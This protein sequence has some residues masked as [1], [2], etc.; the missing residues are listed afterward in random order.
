M[1]NNSNKNVKIH[2]IRL[3]IAVFA[4]IT[5]LVVILSD[6]ISTNNN[7]API[8]IYDVSATPKPSKEPVTYEPEVSNMPESTVPLVSGEPISTPGASMPVQ[9]TSSPVTREPA[10]KTPQ[11]SPTPMTKEPEKTK[12]PVIEQ[13]ETMPPVTKAPQ[14]ETD[15]SDS[16]KE[17]TEQAVNGA[18]SIKA[19]LRCTF[20]N[21]S[22]YF[23]TEK[24][25][26][27]VVFYKESGRDYWKLADTPVYS[28]GDGVYKGSIC[29]L[30]EGKKYDVKIE[31]F[32]NHKLIARK[33][34]N[35]TT[36]T[37]DIKIEKTIKLSDFIKEDSIEGLYLKNIK[38]TSK[39]YIRIIGD[40]NIAS[41]GKGERYIFENGVKK[42][43]L[44]TQE[45][46]NLNYALLLYGCE[47]VVL[48]GF[49]V[50]GGREAGVTIYGE[51]HNIILREF[52]ISQFGP[53]AAY[54]DELGIPYDK[55]DEVI[56][57]V[58][59]LKL[60][61]CQDV[62]FENSKIHSPKVHA[63]TWNEEYDSDTHPQGNSAIH[64][65]QVR[66][67]IVIRNNVLTGSKKAYFMDIIEGW[68]NEY[69]NGGICND[70]DIYGNVFKYANDDA[71][72]LDG[73]QENIRVYD[74]EF[75]NCLCGVSVSPNY[76][77]PSYIFRNTF[78]AMEDSSEKTSQCIK[79]VWNHQIEDGG[80]TFVYHNTFCTK[81]SVFALYREYSY[82]SRLVTAN[83][84]LYVHGTDFCINNYVNSKLHSYDY[85]L[86]Y[87]SNS[88][89]FA[90]NTQGMYEHNG[91]FANPEFVD[92]K[93]GNF[94][95]KSTSPGIDSG[96]VINNFSD[97]YLGKAPDMGR[98][99]KE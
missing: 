95:L 67:G 4:V 1:N 60:I 61:N 53:K 54:Y 44:R 27:A 3:V 55:N 87:N 71:I 36:K 91:V 49:N 9:V 69:D 46:D 72:E 31:L 39:G 83:N 2:I 80:Y 56:V 76:K 75:N 50:K 81:G 18:V 64:L 73:G 78:T 59:G 57:R 43:N 82:A 92:A 65:M 15:L 5:G 62:L 99:E 41:K 35:S 66:G 29:G 40:V 6:F 93:N 47:Y 10:S 16:M 22:Y 23:Y 26:E 37:S 24:C 90:I 45:V 85:D 28:K 96:R 34:A 58:Y 7:L 51:S 84:I 97:G 52:D 48:E 20:E 68:R 74:N 30:K 12:L 77:G 98:F 25:D 86:V 38:G 42:A 88:D 79:T 13:P 32:S 21:M 94:K 11:S 19:E 33:K 14:I 17:S 89:K 63:N 70:S 8:Y